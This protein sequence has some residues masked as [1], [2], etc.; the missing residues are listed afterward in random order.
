MNHLAEHGASSM[1]FKGLLDK[2]SRATFNGKVYVHPRAQHIRAQQA[3]HNLLL[4][5][6]AEVNSKPELEIYADDIKCAHG[7]TV[8]QLDAESLFFLRARGIDK[9]LAIDLLTQAF[10]AEV[11]NRIENAAVRRYVEDRAG[12]SHE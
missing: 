10:S 11:F 5:P 4:S 3:N 12:I 1:L 6:H 2:K 7:A 9:E 8:G